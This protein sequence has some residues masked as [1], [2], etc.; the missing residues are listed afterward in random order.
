[1]GQFAD[2]LRAGID[3]AARKMTEARLVGDHYGA[4]SYRERLGFLRRVAGRHGL[5]PCPAR[6]PPPGRQG[7][8][9]RTLLPR[10]WA[11]VL[12]RGCW[13]RYGR[14]SAATTRSASAPAIAGAVAL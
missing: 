4:E 5:G 2:E 8:A 13:L 10:Y 7:P 11:A 9:P 3:E 14:G 1:M 6:N 12:C